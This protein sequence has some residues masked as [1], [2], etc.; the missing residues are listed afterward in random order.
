[1]ASRPGGEPS[2]RAARHGDRPVGEVADTCLRVE[3]TLKGTLADQVPGGRTVLEL[4][5]GAPAEAILAAVGLPVAPYIYAINGVA[6]KGSAPL[7]DGD[8]VVV[9]PPM[10]GG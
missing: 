1:M 6:E 4:P 9:Y 7:Y 10:A 3:V 5:V 2:A 8:R